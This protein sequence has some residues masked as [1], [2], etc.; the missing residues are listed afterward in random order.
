M[1]YTPD[2]QY[3]DGLY[4]DANVNIQ[5]STEAL[6]F[7][8]TLNPVLFPLAPFEYRRFY[9][10]GYYILQKHRDAKDQELQ[11]V[12]Y[13][14]HNGKVNFLTLINGVNV[15]SFAHTRTK[16][17]DPEAR[18][19]PMLPRRDYVV[20]GFDYEAVGKTKYHM[21][22]HCI[23]HADTLE[24]GPKASYS[25]FDRRNYIPEPPKSYWGLYIRNPLSRKI[26]K[27]KGGYLQFPYY[28]NV[29]KKTVDGTFVPAGVFF[30]EVYDYKV[31]KTYNVSW[32][33]NRSLSPSKKG[34]SLLSNFDSHVLSTPKAPLYDPL[35]SNQTVNVLLENLKQARARFETGDLQTKA[36]PHIF[37]TYDHLL[38]EF[39]YLTPFYKLQA[40]LK[41]SKMQDTKRAERHLERALHHG[42]FLIELD[43]KR[44]VLEADHANNCYELFKN[45]APGFEDKDER[46]VDRMAKLD[47]DGIQYVKN[48]F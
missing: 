26:R 30:S 22:G 14:P 7:F 31:T 46:Q 37:K 32:S 28:A 15:Q 19:Y 38:N 36:H 29:L 2:R 9:N 21:P 44:T 48:L 20:R 18:S 40:A 43:D 10:N 16:T 12:L 42:E 41:A 11:V 24:V 6:E 13:G 4:V 25:T 34:L 35:A 5:G 3:V 23:D 33:F 8:R 45:E 1:P 47:K 17:F 39:E 27:A